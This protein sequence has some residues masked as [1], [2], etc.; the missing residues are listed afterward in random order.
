MQKYIKTTN[1]NNKMRFFQENI[2]KKIPN[3]ANWQHCATRC[4]SL[5]SESLV[6]IEGRFAPCY[7]TSIFFTLPSAVRTMFTPRCKLL[8]RTPPRV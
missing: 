8:V 3:Q 6:F 7:F 5:D 2:Q 1:N 4:N